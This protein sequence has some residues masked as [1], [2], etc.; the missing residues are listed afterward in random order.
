MYRTV[1]ISIIITN[2]NIGIK[3]RKRK[4]TTI[5][6]QLEVIDICMLIGVCRNL[7]NNSI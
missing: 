4:L 3:Q 2:H 6:S 1:Y 5:C 7:L